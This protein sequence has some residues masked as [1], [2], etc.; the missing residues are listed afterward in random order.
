MSVW[1]IVENVSLLVFHSKTWRVSTV[2]YSFSGLVI[3]LYIRPWQKC[4]GSISISGTMSPRL[5]GYMAG[6][7]NS[8]SKGLYKVGPIGIEKLILHLR[9]E[10]G[11]IGN[12]AVHKLGA[13]MALVELWYGEHCSV[14]MQ[15]LVLK[16]FSGIIHCG[17][18]LQPFWFSTWVTRHPV[19][20]WSQ[21]GEM[22]SEF[23][24]STAL[25]SR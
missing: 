18:V 11:P 19:L 23:C 17:C 25:A 4:S 15:R 16:T 12:H 10:A 1:K 6:V 13:S 22:Q 5:F 9:Y 20:L 14:N 3:P 24:A 8:R 21:K 7:Q 2:S